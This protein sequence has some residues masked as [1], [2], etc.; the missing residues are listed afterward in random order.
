MSPSCRGTGIRHL[1]T[2]EVPP[3][4][5]N[6]DLGRCLR[7]LNIHDA[8]QGSRQYRMQDR[9]QKSHHS[10]DATNFCDE[11][12]FESWCGFT[13]ERVHFITPGLEMA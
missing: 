6:N 1:Q 9:H 7:N 12:C 5:L 13:Q 2:S 11:P 10:S 3:Q 4:I 8:E